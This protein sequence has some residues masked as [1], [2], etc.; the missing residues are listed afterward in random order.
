MLVDESK[1][2]FIITKS[3]NPSK[4]Y[5]LAYPYNTNN[6]VSLIGSLPYGGVVSATMS[7]NKII[8]KTYPALFY[9]KPQRNQ[10]I[11]QNPKNWLYFPALRFRTLGRSCKFR[12]RWLRVLYH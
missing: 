5:K 10:S 4:I 8:V 2:I 1:N 3:G 11:E 12:K 9:Y 6:T 7:A